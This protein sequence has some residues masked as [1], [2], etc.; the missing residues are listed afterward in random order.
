MRCCHV[1]GR[2]RVLD[3]GPWRG[4]VR[5]ASGPELVEGGW[6]EGRPARRRYFEIETGNGAHLWV[7]QDLVED[8]WFLHGRFE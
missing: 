8:R 3:R 5:C 1:Q 7:F 4:P 6:W 2:P